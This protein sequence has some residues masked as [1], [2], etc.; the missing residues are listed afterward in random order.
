MV[1]PIA[2]MGIIIRNHY[3]VCRKR[4]NRRRG[5]EDNRRRRYLIY[6]YR[7]M[8]MQVALVTCGIEGLISDHC[9]WSLLCVED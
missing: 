4:T 6:I 3:D 8:T 2:V 7:E 5:E 9:C 1:T